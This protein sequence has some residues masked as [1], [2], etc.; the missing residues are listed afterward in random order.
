MSLYKTLHELPRYKDGWSFLYVEKARIERDQNAV[1]FGHPLGRIAVP[2]AMLASLLLG[3]GTAL[4][5]A[6]MRLLGD[7]GTS[8]VWVG[9]GASK[10]YAAGVQSKRTARNLEHQARIWADPGSRMEVVRRMYAMRFDEALDPVLTIEQVRGKE[11]VRVRQAYASMAQATGVTWNGRA[12][13]R[14]DWIAADPV[15]RALSTANACLHAICHAAILAVG[16]SPG[17]GFIH[18]GSNRAF[19]F[20]VADLYKCDLTIPIAF[21][22]VAIGTDQL[23]R[24]V[25]RVCRDV[26]FEKRIIQ[27]IVPDMLSVLGLAAEPV[28]QASVRPEDEPELVLWDPEQGTVPGGENYG[29]AVD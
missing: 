21:K 11:G 14:G 22:S 27:R 7:S 10:V 4:T 3:P 5:H 8:V 19:V 28:F 6:A 9:E 15:N 17:L 12:Y 26:F 1:V 13:R 20:D 29:S 24:N 16:F 2:S 23:E 18:S 25:R